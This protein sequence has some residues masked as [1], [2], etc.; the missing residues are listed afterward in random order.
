M[1]LVSED[2]IEIVL[3]HVTGDSR[4]TC[5]TIWSNVGDALP[6]A[7]FSGST[8]RLKVVG[9]VQES[10]N[11]SIVVPVSAGLH[12]PM[13][14]LP[15]NNPENTISATV[16]AGNVL[17]TVVA[18]SPSVGHVPVSVEYHPVHD[19]TKHFFSTQ[20]NM[21]LHK[22]V[23]RLSNETDLLPFRSV[24]GNSSLVFTVVALRNLTKGEWLAAE[25]SGVVGVDGE[26]FDVISEIGRAHV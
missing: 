23:T 8:L 21:A 4:S 18:S 6:A 14:A 12:L 3:Q 26:Y 24:H 25:L 13:D 22:H 20:F 10:H 11:V 5:F 1:D 19:D 2:V 9:K 17:P 7:T 16:S 15:I